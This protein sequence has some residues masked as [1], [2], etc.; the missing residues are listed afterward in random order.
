MMDKYASMGTWGSVEIGARLEENLMTA[1]L[2]TAVLGAT[3]YSGLELARLLGRHPRTDAP[4]LLRRSA[5][6]DE[7]GDY[8]TPAANGSNGNGHSPVQPFR[9]PR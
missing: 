2:K 1:K 3:G 5:E 7:A 9:G 4:L 8:R 6:T